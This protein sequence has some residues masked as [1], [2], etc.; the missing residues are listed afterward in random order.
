MAGVL[1]LGSANDLATELAIPPGVG[2]AWSVVQEGRYEEIDLIDVNGARFATC[3]GLGFA[4]DVA[5]LAA[6]WKSGEGW[7]GRLARRVGSLVYLLATA[8]E[9][10]R[11]RQ[12]IETTLRVSGTCLRETMSMVIVSNQ[13]RIGAHFSPSPDASNRDGLVHTCAVRAPHSRLRLLW[14][15]F[16]LFRGRADRCREIRQIC[17]ESLTI[18]TDREMTFF[19]DGEP[20]SSSKRFRIEVLP[21]ALRVASARQGATHRED[22]LA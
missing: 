11:K 7:R 19:G 20:L 18:E 6:R 15:C 2:P 12:P 10:W 1:P 5:V 3:G 4:T 13:P 14:I 21:S 8:T 16:Q 9:V 22:I 17:S